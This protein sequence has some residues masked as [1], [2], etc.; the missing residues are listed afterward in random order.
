MPI[1]QSICRRANHG[2]R[3]ESIRHF[4]LPRGSFRTLMRR[5]L[6]RVTC[7]SG[8]PSLSSPSPLQGDCYILHRL[9]LSLAVS[10][11]WFALVLHTKHPSRPALAVPCS[12]CA[13]PLAQGCFQLALGTLRPSQPRPALLRRHHPIPFQ[14]L[15][16]CFLLPLGLS[17]LDGLYRAILVPLRS[18]LV[19]T[20]TG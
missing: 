19:I 2:D 16:L 20:L 18:R 13:R 11:L 10:G 6:R 14:P 12:I 1:L 5:R 3:L 9:W 8:S 4:C 17:L 15:A 7:C